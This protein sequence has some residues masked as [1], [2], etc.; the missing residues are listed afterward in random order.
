MFL[1]ES[2]YYSPEANK[3]F[4]SV[5]QYKDF[6]GTWAKPGCEARAMAKLNGEWEE[7]VTT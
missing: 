7:E 1:T 2:N 3:E 5:S 6:I 4:L